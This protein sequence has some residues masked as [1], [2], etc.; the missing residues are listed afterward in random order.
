V[1]SLARAD[2]LAVV[3]AEVDAVREGDAVRV[4]MVP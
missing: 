1:A 2:A 4:M 3:D